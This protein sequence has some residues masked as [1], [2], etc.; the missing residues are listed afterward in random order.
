[1]I[2]QQVDSLV[3]GLGDRGAAVR[4]EDRVPGRGSSLTAVRSWLTVALRGQLR[5]VLIGSL[6][7]PPGDHP[8]LIQRQPALP[9][10]L[11]AAGKLR[12]PVRDGGDRVRVRRGRAGLPGHQRRHRPRAGGTAQLVAI[13]LGH[14]LHDAPINRVA[15]TGQLRQL[16]EQH[17]KTLIRTRHTSVRGCGRGHDTIIAAGSDKSRPPDPPRGV[18]A[19]RCQEVPPD[20]PAAV[21]RRTHSVF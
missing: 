21:A 9:H 10:A 20:R 8:D 15:L 17:L 6:G 11:R 5:I 1:M 19:I 16:L 18:A 3:G 13:H 14:D 12:Q 4:A 7:R 2:R